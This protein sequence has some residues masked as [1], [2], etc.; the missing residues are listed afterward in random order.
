[1]NKIVYQSI[2]LA[3]LTITPFFSSQVMAGACPTGTDT[4][5]TAGCTIGTSSTTYTMTGN[6]SPTDDAKGIVLSLGFLFTFT[7]DIK[8]K[9][10]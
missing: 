7:I 6:M 5:P 8:F 4:A 1:M 2:W 3:G 10:T 9:I